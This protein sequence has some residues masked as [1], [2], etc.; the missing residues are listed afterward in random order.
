M[1]PT[2]ASV[3]ESLHPSLEKLIS[4]TPVSD[5]ALPRDMP[6]QGVYL[7]S[8]GERHLYVGRSNSLR[9]RYRQHS[10]PSSQHNQAVFAFKLARE[11]TGKIKA[12]YV[13]GENSRVGLSQ[14]PIFL[15][16]FTESK[17]RV[18]KM[19]YRFVEEKDQTQQ[20]LLELYCAI[21][22]GCPYNDFN[23]H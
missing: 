9:Q 21:S 6:S 12:G 7:F 23:T 10:I 16:A 14:D 19:G 2:F 17:V 1:N 20:A 3:V 15:K 18:R 22:L 13:P 8:E 11:V 5:G 4:M